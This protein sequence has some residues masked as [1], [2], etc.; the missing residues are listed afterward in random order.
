[1]AQKHL[2]LFYSYKFV[3]EKFRVS[4]PILEKF[5]EALEKQVQRRL[6]QGHQ[7]FFQGR[8]PEALQEYQAA[9][10]LAFKFLHP[11]FPDKV[12]SLDP[13]LARGFKVF[14]ALLAASG[15]VARYRQAAGDRGLIISPDGPP[16]EVVALV[17]QFGGA[18]AGERP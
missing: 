11:D 13:S 15:A 3:P 10:T 17:E 8:Y 12:I 1:M 18:G 16:E 4:F 2:S 5:E 14:D 7:Q 6:A 9:Y